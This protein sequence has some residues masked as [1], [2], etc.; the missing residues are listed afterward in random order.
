M[1]QQLRE[2]FFVAAVR[3]APGF[4]LAVRCTASC[5]RLD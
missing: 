1:F 3:G 5:S 2:K 4:I